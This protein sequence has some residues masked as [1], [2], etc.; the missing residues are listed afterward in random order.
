MISEV[1]RDVSPTRPVLIAGPTASGKSALALAIAETQGGVVVNADA[2]QVFDCWQVLTARPDA[3]EL[4]RAP[5][6]LYGH[7]PYD[8]PYSAGH[9]LR[10]V[11]PLLDQGERPIIVG[12]TG[13]YF[14]ALTQGLAD[15]PASPQAIR[16]EADT[17]SLETLTR[18]IAPETLA[19]LDRQNRARVQRAWEVEQAT[20]TPLH[21]WQAQKTEACLPPDTATCFLLD[22]PKDWLS[23]RIE[24]R[25]EQMLNTGGL[26]EAQA[27]EDR[28]DPSLSSCKAIGVPE[29][30]ALIKGHISRDEA[31]E[32]ATIATRQYAKR[33]RTW[34]KAR[35]QD[36]Q[37]LPAADL[38]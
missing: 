4:A 11:T 28:Y 29:T 38:C 8:A 2:S 9:W 12:G 31:T 14:H 19:G 25:F 26:E 18:Q 10:E 35:M 7:L 16:D 27:M 34:F 37:H 21:V 15:I 36:W 17:L 3:G 22:A 5:H 33:Q 32:R 1:L 23:P 6:A 24:A 20:G 13:L 30:M